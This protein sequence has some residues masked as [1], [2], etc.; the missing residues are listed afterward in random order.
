[1]SAAPLE[2]SAFISYAN[3][4]NA[5]AE[6]ICDHLEAQGMRCWMAPRDVRAGKEYANEI[7]LGI[8]R[9]RCLVLVLS[10]AANGSQFVKR[11]VERAVT[12]GRPVIP[13]RI[14]E[15]L[16]SPGLELFVS[17]TH[18]IEGWNG[19]W[20]DDM[21][22]VVRAVKDAISAAPGRPEAPRRDDGDADRWKIRQV[23]P[24]AAAVV[25]IAALAGVAYQYASGEG[26]SPSSVAP[27]ADPVTSPPPRPAAAPVPRPLESA[28]SRDTPST[29]VTAPTTQTAPPRGA[30]RPPRPAAVQ[31]PAIPPPAQNAVDEEALEE[32][33]QTGTMLT[34]LTRNVDASL[35][36]LGEQ[37]RPNGLRGDIVLR[38]QSAAVSLAAGHR[39][40]DRGNV[41][42]A[43]KYF[44]QARSD[45]EALLR[46]LG[47]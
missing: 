34:V 18:W 29:P 30:E 4:D 22:Q 17:S 26:P 10:T 36:R 19:A 44:D 33:R 21:D 8:E 3:A 2:Y 23:L 31:P 7:I 40:L 9:S 15:V 45:L 38:Q 14:E 32:M 28:A 1:M 39:A 11:E 13:V 24:R 46:F 20:S 6:E 5:K 37:M 27:T 47:R 25:L 12:K 35:E 41:A 42:A 16:P 43:K